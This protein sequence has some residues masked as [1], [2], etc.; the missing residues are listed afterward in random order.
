M[1]IEFYWIGI[2]LG[3]LRAAVEK[4]KISSQYLSTQDAY[5]WSCL[6]HFNQ[7][8]VNQEAQVIRP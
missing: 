4:V 5:K 7:E 8:L 6:T 3:C 2:T 1:V